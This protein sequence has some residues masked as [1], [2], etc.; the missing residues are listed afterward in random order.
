MYKKRH[1]YKK[2]SVCKC[3]LREESSNPDENGGQAEKLD[4]ALSG[5]HRSVGKNWKALLQ[6]PG[7][8]AAEW[9]RQYD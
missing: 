3:R 9:C 8:W 7:I 5:R 2:I 6:M 4:F 1:K